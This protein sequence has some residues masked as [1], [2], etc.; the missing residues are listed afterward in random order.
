MIRNWTHKY[1]LYYEEMIPLWNVKKARDPNMPMA[2]QATMQLCKGAFPSTAHFTGIPIK[3][4]FH[5]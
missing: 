1:E 2:Q 5:V 4:H 3:A